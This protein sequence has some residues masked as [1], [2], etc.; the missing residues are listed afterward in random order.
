MPKFQSGFPVNASGEIVISGTG[1]TIVGTFPTDYLPVGADG[2][3]LFNSFSSEGALSA[4]EQALITNGAVFDGVTSD[5]AAIQTSIN[6]FYTQYPNGVARF[7]AGKSTAINTTLL[8][9]ASKSS[10]DFNGLTINCVPMGEGTT[11]IRIDG[12]GTDGFGQARKFITGFTLL[13]TGKTGTQTAV[14]CAGSS[15]AAGGPGPNRIKISHFFIK[16]FGTGFKFG[17]NSYALDISNFEIYHAGTCIYYP[18]GQPDSGERSTF[19]QGLLYLS[20]VAVRIDGNHGN[21][22]FFD[23]MSFDHT[24]RV[25]DV[26]AK[27]K[28]FATNFH[29][30][31]SDYT[32]APIIGTGDGTLIRLRDGEIVVTNPSG[33]RTM[34]NIVDENITGSGG[35]FFDGVDFYGCNV[36]S[37]YVSTGARTFVNGITCRSTDDMPILLSPLRNCL[38]DGGF[39]GAIGDDLICIYK[40]TAAITD[41]YVGTNG[42]VS[43]SSTSPRTG[44]KCLKITKVGSTGTAFG[45]MLVIPIRNMIQR[46]T[47]KGYF[48]TTATGSFT[49]NPVY[50]RLQVD[51]NGVFVNKGTQVTEAQQSKSDTSGTWLITV[52]TSNGLSTP[53]DYATHYGI[54]IDLTSKGA[55]DIYFDDIEMALM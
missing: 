45:V 55:G 10:I 17:P 22:L 46:G 42:S 48:K 27:A 1:D 4:F 49:I 25:F 52:S 30:E 8:L 29:I 33:T 32:I 51:S 15:G 41:P 6:W 31:N 26:R 7:P 13:G 54:F 18:D 43:Y 19:S 23:H 14:L 3:L 39:E 35:V 36:T 50:T 11:A 37:R 5:S 9:D 47:F 40:D 28:L 21:W 44:S 38:K 20:D 12:T 34:P 24:G 53:P 16:D 2:G